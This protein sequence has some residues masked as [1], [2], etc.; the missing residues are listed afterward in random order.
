MLKKIPVTRTL[1]PPNI[2]SNFL[3]RWKFQ[4]KIGP[5]NHVHFDKKRSRGRISPNLK[6]LNKG[7]RC[8]YVI[9]QDKH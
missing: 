6:N 4:K 1:P 3:H 2:M 9:D 8:R 5:R 7:V